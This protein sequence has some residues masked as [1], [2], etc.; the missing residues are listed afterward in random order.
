M[1]PD[2]FDVMEITPNTFKSFS[3]FQMMLPLLLERAVHDN[4]PPISAGV[5]NHID[6]R[7]SHLEIH[8]ATKPGVGHSLFVGIN[9][10]RLSCGRLRMRNVDSPTKPEEYSHRAV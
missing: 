3:V 6:E 4:G 5:R 1:D 9:R 10:R 8:L 7:R 2:G